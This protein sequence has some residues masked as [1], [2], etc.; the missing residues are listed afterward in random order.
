M[1]HADAS[2]P[3]ETMALGA[4]LDRIPSEI[5]NIIFAMAVEGKAASTDHS[6]TMMVERRS[7]K[8]NGTELI[9]IDM[10]T[11][12]SCLLTNSRLRN[13]SLPFQLMIMD[14]I[15]HS[16]TKVTSN[17]AVKDFYNVPNIAKSYHKKVK[18]LEIDAHLL[19]HF[20]RNSSQPYQIATPLALLMFPNI[21]TITAVLKYNDEGDFSDRSN[22]LEFEYVHKTVKRMPDGVKGD[23]EDFI[24]GRKG[25]QAKLEIVFAYGGIMVGRKNSLGAGMS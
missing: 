17:N 7:K 21:E 14:N 13:A 4:C 1:N 25:Y 8:D 15:K 6:A 3:A 11:L 9:T 24:F 2:S 12:L 5:F 18:A 20:Q 19:P 10:S 23:V 16:V 22:M